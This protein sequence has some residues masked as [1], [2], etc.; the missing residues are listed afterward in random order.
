MFMRRGTRGTR[1]TVVAAL[2]LAALATVTACG[3]EKA[4]GT[5]E[6]GGAP[7]TGVHWSVDSM[8]VDGRT[9]RAPGGAYLEFVSDERVRGDYGCNHFD[10]EA[11]VTDDSVDLGRSATTMMQCT[12]KKVRAFEKS[13][14]RA[15]ADRNTVKAAGDDDRLTLTRAN[16]D[17]V[18]LTKGERRDAPLTGTK[19]QLTTV[20]SDD[21]AQSVPKGA[22]GR[23]GLVFGKDGH[24]S[25]RLGCNSA[26]AA[27]KVA[28]GHITFGPLAGTKMGC[29]GAAAEVEKTMRNVLEGRASYD[30]QGD[31]LTLNAPD[32]TGIG[33]TATTG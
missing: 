21:V 27:A 30:V 11:R 8:T 16:G 15:L 6:V 14:A 24:V 9:T 20:Y 28:D 31:A 22:Q 18:T 12:D 23:A 4:P 32:G 2:P 3:N 5:V 17:T 7:V 29:F 10:A 19:W 25:A 1:S 33:L 13:L 26:R